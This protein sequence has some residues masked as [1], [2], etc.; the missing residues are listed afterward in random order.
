MSLYRLLRY[1]AGTVIAGVL[2]WFI[3]PYAGIPHSHM[4][5]PS[6][7]YAKAAG[8][9]NGA[10]TKK[11]Y[12]VTN[13]PF[14]VGAHMWFVDYQFQADPPNAPPHTPKQT[15]TGE[16]RVEQADYDKAHTEGA[17][18]VKYEETYPWI[19]GLMDQ[20]SLGTPL[21]QSIGEG[22]NILSGWLIWVAATLLLGYF[23]MLILEQFG[24]KEDM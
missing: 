10:I 4:V 13:N 2:I 22:S 1:L 12:L 16:V 14:N 8:Q 3:A 24:P 18:N 6:W 19:N 17:V 23:V 5:P 9:S 7:I 20:S 15:Y 21:G 11:Y